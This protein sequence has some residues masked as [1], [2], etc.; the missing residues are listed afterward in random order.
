MRTLFLFILCIGLFSP[1][2]FAQGDLPSGGADG[3]VTVRV[4]G[5]DDAGLGRI[6][7]RIAKEQQVN[8]EYT[9]LRSGI[10]VLHFQALQVSERADVITVVKRLFQQAGITGAIEFLDIHVERS[11]LN[12]C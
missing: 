9:C 1:A 10:V 8:L 6:S 12:K 2:S 4:D 11:A 5:L 3:L 7:A